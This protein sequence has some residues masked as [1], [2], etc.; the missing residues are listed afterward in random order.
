MPDL[1]ISNLPSLPGASVQGKDPVAIADLSAAETK[2]ITVKDLLQGG[3][4]T[5]DDGSIPGDKISGVPIAPG[6]I[7]TIELADGAVTTDKLDDGAVTFSK[8]QD[9]N[10]DV[11]LGRASAG[12][13]QVEQIVCTAAGRALLDDADAAAQRTTLGLGNLATV[14]G[15][16]ADGSSVSGDNTGDQTITLTG[17]VT[18]S[19]TG[20]FDTTISANAIGSTEIANKS[21]T[22]AKIQDVSKGDVVLGRVTDAGTVEEIT[23]TA[24]G[25]ALIDDADAA[26]QRVTL[27]LGSLATA[28]GTWVNGSS[29]SGTSSGTNTGDQTITL[30]G[31]VTGS[32]TSTFATEIAAGVV[33]TNEIADSSVTYTKTNFA[34]GSI[35]GAKLANDINGSKLVDNTVTAAKVSADSLDRGLDKTTGKIGIGNDTGSD[36]TT[37]NGIT[38]NRQGLITSSAALSGTDL[39]PATSKAI[40]AV[41]PGTGLTV[42]SD[43]TLNHSNSVTASSFAGISFDKEGH[44]T[45]VSSTGVITPSSLPPAGTTADRLGAVYV[46][47]DLVVGLTVNPTNGELK[48]EASGVA[49]GSYVNVTVDTNG[50]ITAGSDKNPVSSIPDLDASIITSGQFGTER[51]EDDAINAKK[52]ADYSTCLMQEDHP[53]AGHFLGQF[54]YTPSTAQ[55]RVYSRGSGPQNIWL[56][57]GFGLLQQQNL[58]FAFTFDATTSTITSITQ[59]GAP[60]GLQVGDP[61][62]AANDAN[63]GA[64]GI[65]VVEGAGIPLLDVN[66]V[67][68]TVGDWIL[69][70]GATAGWQHINTVDGNSG[71]G[72]A[73]FLDDLLDVTIGGPNP[74]DINLGPNVA[75]AVALQDGDILRYYS[76]IGQWVNAPERTVIPTSAD[77]PDDARDGTLWWDSDSGRLFVSYDDGNTTQW[78]PATPETGG[79][80]GGG[81]SGDVELLND[82]GD[83]FAANTDKAFL[84]YNDQNNRWESTTTIDGGAF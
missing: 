26:T 12:V 31:D 13:G 4:V 9:I 35:P 8:I 58:R 51:I 52:L 1:E 59:Y 56:P 17:D 45:G 67:N 64:Y 60:L 18:G 20:T 6:E 76:S 3:I 73:Q 62:P 5:I 44:I 22:Y 48:H 42:T 81:G 40:G 71:G 83:V 68:F 2:K 21:V 23:C 69:S 39:P 55:L 80:S 70:A 14:N 30:T 63:A 27:G 33:G 34:D 57:V 7:G 25:R 49:A 54:W 36:T 66:G 10:T 46:P 41:K 38:Y 19:G 65:C 24:A 78:V 37:Q 53:G 50:H 47:S 77:P 28:S 74:V 29:F 84:Q 79:N 15:T 43:G 61:I 72:G 11:V 32:G 16:W 82:L 75:P